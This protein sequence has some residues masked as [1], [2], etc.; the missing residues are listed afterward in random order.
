MAGQ[1]KRTSI[2]HNSD[3][4]SFKRELELFDN[5][6]EDDWEH[7]DNEYLS[8][9]ELEEEYERDKKNTRCLQIS[10]ENKRWFDVDTPGN[11]ASKE[12]QS[13]AY[14]DELPENGQLFEEDIVMDDY[15]RDVLNGLAGK[16]DAVSLQSYRWPERTIYYEFGPNIDYA[17]KLV[18]RRAIEEYH[19]Y[20]CIR[21]VEKKP[22]DGAKDY[23]QFISN[24]SACYSNVGR[25]G[26]MQVVSI[27]FG[28]LRLGT[29][30]H[31]IMHV[32]G[33]FHEM[34]RPDRDETIKIHWENIKAKF[35]HNFRIIAKYLDKQLICFNIMS[36]MQYSNGAFSKNGL[37]T[38]TSR[39]DPNKKFGQR[40]GFSVGDIKEINI[41]YNCP[42]YNKKLGDKKNS[43]TLC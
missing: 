20:T 6:M 28:C 23:V 25:R 33:F 3:E 4:R 22:G 13:P 12:E 36:V 8:K 10:N 26:G 32:L 31:E 40:C 29:P 39:V 43:E 27:G 16:R 42:E 37:D 9:H 11:D 21:F 17:S 15:V 41:L 30:I 34:A 7:D 19:K 24:G 18:I 38:I 1:R 35:K 5:E 14:D 2:S